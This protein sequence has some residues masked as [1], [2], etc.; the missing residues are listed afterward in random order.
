MTSQLP[1]FR[2]FSQLRAAKKPT[3]NGA[4]VTSL[5][6]FLFRDDF[7]D[8][9]KI[10][11]KD[12]IPFFRLFTGETDTGFSSKKM[13]RAWLPRAMLTLSVESRPWSP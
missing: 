9:L 7:N 5:R 10:K 2:S 1:R 8:K 12:S 3:E 6:S 13:K 11:T 4:A